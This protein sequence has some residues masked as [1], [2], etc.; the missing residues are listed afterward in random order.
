M[1][2]FKTIGASLIVALSGWLTTPEMVQ[3]L[4]QYPGYVSTGIGALFTILRWVTREPLPWL[5]G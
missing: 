3:F 4:S 5:K 2:G 1:N